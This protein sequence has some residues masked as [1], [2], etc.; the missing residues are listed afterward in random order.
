M[1]L[2]TASDTLDGV[3]RL[4]P[5]KMAKSLHMHVAE[6]GELNLRNREIKVGNSNSG[7]LRCQ[8][9]GFLV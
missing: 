7:N 4:V 2:Q 3:Y 1:I 9:E 6:Y 5:A 8:G